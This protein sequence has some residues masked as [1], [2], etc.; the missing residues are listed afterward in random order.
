MAIDKIISASITDG[1]IATADI[2]DG[3][4]TSVKTTGVGGDMTPAFHAFLSSSQT[5]L[6][7]GSEATI[8]CTSEIYDTDS[9]Y[10]TST[11]KFTPQTA[12][13]YFVYVQAVVDS[14][15]NANLV[16]SDLY[17][18]KNTTLAGRG[19]MN[20]QGNQ[21][22]LATLYTSAVLDMNGSS[23]YVIA[24]VYADTGSGNWL[25]T[26]SSWQGTYFGAYKIIT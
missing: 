12:G 14:S 2:A 3:A 25:I 6:S 1:T 22:R 15:G 17:L 4:V 19:N 21:I 20:Y 5:G 13:K 26:G 9:A 7:D 8:A 23:D 24:K 18:Y 10:D 11:Y 16:G